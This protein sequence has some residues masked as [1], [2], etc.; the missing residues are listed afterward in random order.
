MT[1]GAICRASIVNLYDLSTMGPA[2]ILGADWLASGKF[3]FT[4][5][6]V[7]FNSRELSMR[8]II[9]RLYFRIPFFIDQ[10]NI[11]DKYNAC[12]IYFKKNP[13]YAGS[14]GIL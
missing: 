1:Y 8:T 4:K 9:D 10:L 11:S 13:L 14:F 5:S 7:T 2:F 3:R 12:S 6:T